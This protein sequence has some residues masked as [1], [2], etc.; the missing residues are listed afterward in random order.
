MPKKPVT[1]DRITITLDKDLLNDINLE[2][3]ERTMKVSSYV[4]KLIKLG[5]KNDKLRVKNLK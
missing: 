2:C 5:L 1:K 4:E 3:E